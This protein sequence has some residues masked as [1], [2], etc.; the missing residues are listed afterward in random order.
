MYIRLCQTWLDQRPTTQDRVLRN[1]KADIARRLLSRAKTIEYESQSA[2]E[3]EDQDRYEAELEAE[4]DDSY[5]KLDPL[6]GTR[7]RREGE[8]RDSS[9]QLGDPL[10]PDIDPA[11]EEN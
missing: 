8:L 5:S 10:S 9:A 3:A 2:P 4:L 11:Q 1:I 6:N 7:P